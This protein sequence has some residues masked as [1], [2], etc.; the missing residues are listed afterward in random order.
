MIRPAHRNEVSRQFVSQAGIGAV[1]QVPL[2]ER[3]DLA[4]HRAYRLPAGRLAPCG[5]PLGAL[6][7]SRWGFQV[8]LVVASGLESST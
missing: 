2:A 1:M 8:G 3:P 6:S 4:S 5:I 7:V